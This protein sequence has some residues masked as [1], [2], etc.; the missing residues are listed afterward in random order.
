MLRLLSNAFRR[1]PQLQATA[2]RSTSRLLSA[3]TY[4]PSEAIVGSPAPT[5]TA[6]AVVDGDLSQVDLSKYTSEGK[7]SLLL[8]YPKVGEPIEVFSPCARS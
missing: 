8:F 6:P 1:A 2:L 3:V 4:P 5:F 7:W